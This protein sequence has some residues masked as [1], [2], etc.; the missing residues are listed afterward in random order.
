[1]VRL[2]EDLK[3]ILK[4]PLGKTGALEQIIP[5]AKGR[6]IIAVGDQV[7]FG[8]LSKG[9]RPHVAVFDFRTMRME[10]AG[11]V[12]ERIEKEYPSPQKITNPPGT[13]SEELF[14]L[15]PVL[16]KEGGA[17]FVEGEEDLAAFPFILFLDKKSVVLY[18]QP[19]E[20][21]VLVEE[22]SEGKKMVKRIAGKLGL[23]SL[24]NRL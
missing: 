10:V 20:G 23:A 18:G 24:P 5:L 7:V 6:K 4:K 11:G 14:V 19:G 8:L 1:M 2:T 9:I 22:K 17:L 13:I 16:I 15:A 12:R 3:A 21:C